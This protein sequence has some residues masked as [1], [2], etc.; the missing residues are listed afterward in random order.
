[1]TN[2]VP[3]REINVILT[4]LSALLDRADTDTFQLRRAEASVERLWKQHA[5]EPA[6]YYTCKAF[7]EFGKYRREAALS[8]ADNMLKLA[9]NDPVVQ[10]NALSVRV[11]ALDVDRA[12]EL[13][14]QMVVEIK[15]DKDTIKTLIIKAADMMQYHLAAELFG[16]LDKLSVNESPQ[17]LRR[18]S[19][20]R[21]YAAMKRANLSDSDAADRLNAAYQAVRD[22]SYDVWRT[23][24]SVL[25]DG[26]VLYFLHVKADPDQCAQLTF[27][28]ADRLV[29]QFDDPG[30]ELVSFSCRPMDDLSELKGI[31][32]GHV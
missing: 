18:P 16:V 12:L 13:L 6:E 14:Q 21:S 30:V 4:E 8:A 3:E 32:G 27:S 15:D 9:P 10:C 5:V 23:S 7:I 25:Q 2:P 1:M 26:S 29:E 24:R 19:I 17:Y 28:I 11:A 22:E 20:D 31:P